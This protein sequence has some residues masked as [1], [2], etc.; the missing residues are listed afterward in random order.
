MLFV[1]GTALYVRAYLADE[2]TYQVHTWYYG[3]RSAVVA[4]LSMHKASSLV[5][6]AHVVLG[7]RMART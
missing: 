3:S 2:G 6:V 7:A 5:V 1:F 4:E